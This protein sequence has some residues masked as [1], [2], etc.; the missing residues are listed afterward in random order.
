MFKK[1]LIII[2]LAT[3]SIAQ[4]QD[5]LPKFTLLKIG[6]NK[7]QISWSNVFTNC[8]QVSVQ[9]SYD[10]LRFYTTI[11]S[12]QSP[13]L[14]VNGFID[15][16]FIDAVKIYYRIFYVLEDGSY[17][18]TT[19]KAV[20]GEVAI[21]KKPVNVSKA[22]QEADA[23]AEITDKYNVYKSTKDSLFVTLQLQ[24]W[25]LFRDSVRR[26]TKDTLINIAPFDFLI[27]T[28]VAKPIWRPSKYV[29]VGKNGTPVMALSNAK[30]EKY[31][32]I[33]YEE[34]NSILYEL[35]TITEDYLYIDKANFIKSGWY[36]FELF[37]HDVLIDK[38][39][40]YIEPNFQ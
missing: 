16:D 36:N 20:Y 15:K 37:N 31:K 12:T 33:F 2:G 21:I 35:K 34:D 25:R 4:A 17:F 39:R 5:T 24:D 40:I 28:Y 38:N 6:K 22:E 11:F 29:F 23:K 26:E 3:C 10:S 7:A 13:T 8:T 1:F 19:S 9:K 18:F 32:L 30:N 27:K 14:P